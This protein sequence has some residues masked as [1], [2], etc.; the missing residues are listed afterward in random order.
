MFT[1]KSS[2]GTKYSR[3]AKVKFFKGWLPQNLL[4][5]LLNTFSHISSLTEYYPV[6]NTCEKQ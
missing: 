3:M 6:D 1:L 5:P 4:S 2:Y